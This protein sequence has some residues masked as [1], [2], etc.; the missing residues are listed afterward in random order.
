[1]QKNAYN[2]REEARAASN[3]YAALAAP[4][5]AEPTAQAVQGVMSVSHILDA[6]WAEDVNIDSLQLRYADRFIVPSSAYYAP[7]S[8]NCIRT[9][10][11]QCGALTF[12]QLDGP[13]REHVSKCYAATGFKRPAGCG[14]DDSLAAELSFMAYL[15][16][17]QANVE[18]DDVARAALDWQ[19][20]FLSD[21]LGAWTQTAMRVLLRSDDD[22]YAHAAALVDAW[23]ELDLERIELLAA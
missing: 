21:H 1:M 23:C 7:L 8:E 13:Y 17:V 20:R 14:R 18:A 4:F 19:Q 6:H 5:A 15:A 3:V 12:G 22:F 11:E 10:S 16:A 9:A 2:A